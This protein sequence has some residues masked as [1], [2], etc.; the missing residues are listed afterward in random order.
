MKVYNLFTTVHSSLAIVDI[1]DG[2]SRIFDFF[3]LNQDDGNLPHFTIP[4]AIAQKGYTPANIVTTDYLNASLGI[5]IFSARFKQEMEAELTGDLKF[6]ECLI[7]CYHEEHRFFMGK[8]KTHIALVDRERSSFRKSSDGSSRLAKAV[9]LEEF[10][11]PFLIARDKDFRQKAV[12]SEGF[13]KLAESKN[14]RIHFQ[15]AV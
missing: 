9:Y 10:E 12:V 5:P 11:K 3:L 8:I 13:K 6:F 1:K 7:K 4:L 15:P 2:S 14:L